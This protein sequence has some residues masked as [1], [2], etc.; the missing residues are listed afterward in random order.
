MAKKNFEVGVLKQSITDEQ[1]RGDEYY[2]RMLRAELE[3]QALKQSVS[4]VNAQHEQAK[5]AL[6]KEVSAREDLEI[7]CCNME[8]MLDIA[9]RVH[10]QEKEQLKEIMEEKEKEFA[11]EREKLKTSEEQLR[12]DMTEQYNANLA[13]ER[14]Q[15]EQS[16]KEVLLKDFA[17]EKEMLMKQLA[18]SNDEKEK[19]QKQLEEFKRQ[20]DEVAAVMKSVA[21]SNFFS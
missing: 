4:E 11:E 3:V 10:T 21:S 16:V 19:V 5:E 9:R 18:E 12:K 8:E 13:A 17:R 20:K 7:K 1:T 6:A 15:T 14:A 2:G